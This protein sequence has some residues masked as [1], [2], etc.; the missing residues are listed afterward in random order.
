MPNQRSREKVQIGGYI[1]K[2]LKKEIELI[3][4]T[5]SKSLTEI[6]ESI[7]KKEVK[8]YEKTKKL[9]HEK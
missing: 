9:P 3:A 7:L 8:I 1:P 5:E 4:R 2:K 6:I